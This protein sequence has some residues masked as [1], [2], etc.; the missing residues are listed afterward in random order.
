MYVPI[1]ENGTPIQLGVRK[2]Y[3]NLFKKVIKFKIIKRFLHIK[4]FFNTEGKISG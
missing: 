2:P 3:I 1:L 4:E